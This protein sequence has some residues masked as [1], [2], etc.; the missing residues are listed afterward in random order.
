[1]LSSLGSSQRQYFGNFFDL[2]GFC[3]SQNVFLSYQ[4]S[5]SSKRELLSPPYLQSQITGPRTLYQ[6]I[7]R[8]KLARCLQEDLL[9]NT[10]I[11]PIYPIPHIFRPKKTVNLL[12]KS[13][14]FSICAAWH[15]KLSTPA[16]SRVTAPQVT[17]RRRLF[18]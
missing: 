7:W 10:E 3:L 9:K 16:C 8:L 17:Y 15:F 5:L 13:V 2:C 11:F 14:I 6:N 12:K 18:I 1:M 4:L